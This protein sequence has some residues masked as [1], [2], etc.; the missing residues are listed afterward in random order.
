MRTGNGIRSGAARKI[1][2][3]ASSNEVMN[4]KIIAAMIDGAMA[5]MVTFS[6]VRTAPAPRLPETSS[7][8][9]SSPARPAPTVRMT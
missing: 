2:T 4:T 6:S 1:D 5:G 3:V 8:A 7:I 9:G